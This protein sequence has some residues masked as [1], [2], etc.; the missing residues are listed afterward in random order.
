MNLQLIIIYQQNLAPLWEPKVKTFL[1]SMFFPYPALCVFLVL[2]LLCLFLLFFFRQDENLLMLL[3][4][5]ELILL[6]LGVFFGTL[7]LSSMAYYPGIVYSLTLLALSA[8]ES[9]IGLS[10]LIVFFRASKSVKL[11]RT[12]LNRRNLKK[13]KNKKFHFIINKVLFF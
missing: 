13:E 2:M 8:A 5:L 7:F 9:V 3:L 12:G 1:N 11:E 10:L 4:Y 6:I